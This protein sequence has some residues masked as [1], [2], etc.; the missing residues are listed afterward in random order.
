MQGDVFG[1]IETE[2]LIAERGIE[3]AAVVRLIG[4]LVLVRSE[5]GARDAHAD[6]GDFPS[7]L[8]HLD[9]LH[10]RRQ[11]TD[12]LLGRK[13]F[14]AA[15]RTSGHALSVFPAFAPLAVK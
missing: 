10:Q 4:S 15:A 13:L 1:A 9:E 11:Q 8:K 5:V 6:D 7:L 3:K 2:G 12:L 14:V